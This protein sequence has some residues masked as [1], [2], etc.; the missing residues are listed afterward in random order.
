MEH[1]VLRYEKE[2]KYMNNE[3]KTNINWYPGHMLKTKKQIIED[4]KLIDVVLEVL[5]A[6]IPMSSQN[7]DI[8]Q[9]ISK[10]KKIVLLNKADLADEK[11]TQ[12][13]I[14]FFNNKGIKTIPTDL[15]LGKGTKEI[16]KQIETVM[17]EELEKAA[18]KGRTNKNIRIMII[19]IPNVGKSSLINRLVNKK[20]A[21]V[22]NRPG[23]TKQKQWVR[24]GKNIELLDT[25]GVL[26]PKFEDEKVALNLAYTGSIKDE[27]LPKTEVAYQLLKLLYTNYKI[28][29]LTNYKLT[30]EDI[31]SIITNVDCDFIL[32][33]MNLIAKK[34]GALISGGEIDYE[35]VAGIILTDFRTGKIGRITLEQVDNGKK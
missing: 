33:L 11:E 26:W 23:V 4:L 16:L 14:S 32:E 1:T 35:K 5:D 34:R 17:Q 9:I 25:P 19:G 22:G 7:P 2:V 8:K 15:N 27:I 13:W 24:I 10:K 12:K 28:E 21:E 18:A 3:N 31:S 20:T 29:F 6:R 30:E